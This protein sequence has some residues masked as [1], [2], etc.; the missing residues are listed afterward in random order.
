MINNLRNGVDTMRE[1]PLKA[2]QQTSLDSHDFMETEITIST[3]GSI[4]GKTKTWTYHDSHGFTG[5]VILYLTNSSNIVLY[6]TKSH[7][8]KV[9]GVSY[10]RQLFDDDPFVKSNRIDIWY[11][12]IPEGILQHVTG[13]AIF[14][15]YE[16]SSPSNI[17]FLIT[18]FNEK[19]KVD[20]RHSNPVLKN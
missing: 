20:S 12:H 7:H 1:F 6:A 5:S 13:S 9:D 4:E 18:P 11:E 17:D 8:Y 16:M 19:S 3:N 15:S 14:H 10:V 2:S